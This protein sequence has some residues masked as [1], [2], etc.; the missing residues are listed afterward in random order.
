MK[1]AAP[2]DIIRDMNAND[3]RALLKA[4]RHSSF[5]AAPLIGASPD[6]IRNW[7][8]GR[9][10]QQSHKATSRGVLSSRSDPLRSKPIPGRRPIG[11]RA[12]SRIARR[13]ASRHD[14]GCP[15]GLR[16]RC[17]PRRLRPASAVVSSV[18]GTGSPD[19]RAGSIAARTAPAKIGGLKNSNAR[20]SCKRNIEMTPPRV[21]GSR[22]MRRGGVVDE[23]AGVQPA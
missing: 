8:S 20:A 18:G 14:G 12:A 9:R 16:N 6:S 2:R 11:D 1:S 7:S 4:R 21:L 10:P 13:S 19:P 3:F 22:E 23:Q 15:D 17:P 5:S